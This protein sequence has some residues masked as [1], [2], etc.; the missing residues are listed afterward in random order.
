MNTKCFFSLIILFSFT[1]LLP[2]QNVGIGTSSPIRKLHIA[3]ALRA[4]TLSGPDMRVVQANSLGDV[5]GIPS[6]ING[7]VLTQ[8]S[9]GPEWEPIPMDSSSLYPKLLSFDHLGGRPLRQTWMDGEYAVTVETAGTIR[10]FLESPDTLP[11]ARNINL[12]WPSVSTFTDVVIRHDYLYALCHDGT[13]TQWR[14]Y[15]YN[16]KNINSGGILMTIIGQPFSGPTTFR[17][18]FDG[19]TFYFNRKAGN[20]VNDFILSKY[21]LSDTTLSYIGDVTCGNTANSFEGFAV[22]LDGSIFGQ[23]NSNGQFIRKFSSSGVLQ[24]ALDNVYKRSDF[25]LVKNSRIY[26]LRYTGNGYTNVFIRMEMP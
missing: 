10:F 5:S 4:D 24:Y 21:S 7:E 25:F 17:M 14:I 8:T 3:G 12:D 1:S 11:Q 2:A 6:G 9:S 22:R 15:R 19:S 18:T 20:S 23:Q 16:R 26:Q 13:L